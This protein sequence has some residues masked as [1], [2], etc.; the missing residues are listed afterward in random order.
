MS[1][2]CYQLSGKYEP[3]ADEEQTGTTMNW[4]SQGLDFGKNSQLKWWLCYVLKTYLSG[5]QQ[6]S[7]ASS[8]Y[9]KKIL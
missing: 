3:A 2:G 9:A 4:L 6:A 5:K 1:S 8:Q 7:L